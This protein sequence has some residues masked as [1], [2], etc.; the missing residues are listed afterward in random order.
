MPRLTGAG[1]IWR[2]HNYE[3]CP[4][5]Q[6]RG[7]YKPISFVLVKYKEVL[8]PPKQCKYCG[9]KIEKIIKETIN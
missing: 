8:I 6:K 7:L 4:N 2:H 1:N 3:E 5:C 9:F